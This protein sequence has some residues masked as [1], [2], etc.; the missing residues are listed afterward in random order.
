MH[1]GVDHGYQDLPCINRKGT[2][3]TSRYA[4]R[5]QHLII[6]QNSQGIITDMVVGSR[7]RLLDKKD[8]HVCSMLV[9]VV[10]CNLIRFF[11]FFDCNNVSHPSLVAYEDSS[12]VKL[13]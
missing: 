4:S 8:D 12:L 9:H 3:I 7:G 6:F 13:V 11:F 2:K 10:C 5:A 1:Q